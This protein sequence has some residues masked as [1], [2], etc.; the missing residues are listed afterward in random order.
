MATSQKQ[1]LPSLKGFH[2]V[3][4]D[5]H[6]FMQQH[7][8]QTPSISLANIAPVIFACVLQNT[9]KHGHRDLLTRI[10]IGQD[11]IASPISSGILAYD[12]GETAE[13]TEPS[14][15][16][17]ETAADRE[18]SLPKRPQSVGRL[19]GLMLQRRTRTAVSS[20]R[21]RNSC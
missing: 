2:A 7:L 14:A 6:Y 10:A 5:D 17:K 8:N 20:P 21:T 12:T 1:S 9:R 15:N 19:S 3:D 18:V 11:T 4:H 13:Q 16:Y